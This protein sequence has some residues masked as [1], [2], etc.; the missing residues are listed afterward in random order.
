MAKTIHVPPWT[1]NSGKIVEFF[2]FR[3]LGTILSNKPNHRLVS[4]K[5]WLSQEM[6]NYRLLSISKIMHGAARKAW[7]VLE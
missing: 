1:D 6:F 3:E 2:L 5:N 4:L 7:R